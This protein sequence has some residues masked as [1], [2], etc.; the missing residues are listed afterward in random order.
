MN[1]H[2]PP[3]AALRWF[4]I[5]AALVYLLGCSRGD[6][7]RAARIAA[8][9]DVSGLERA[10]AEK[11]VGYA[12]DPASLERDLRNF[13]AL[14]EAFR[15][16][17]TG[18]WG[19]E[20]AEEP[21]PKKYVKYTQNYLSRATVDFDAGTIKVET[22][23]EKKPEKSLHTA[24]V[25]TV[26]T[27]EDPRAVDLYSDKPV[28]L[29]E[30]PFLY[31]LVKDFDGKDIR[32]SWRA[33][34]FA[35]QLI[36]TNLK[37]RKIRAAGKEKTVRFVRFP[38]T[39]DRFH[40]RAKKYKP[41]VDQY[42]SRYGVSPNLIYAVIKTESDFN[43]FAVSPVPAFGLMQIVPGTAGADVYQFLHKKSGR[44]TRDAL[45]EPKVNILYGTTYLHML[46]TQYLAEIDNP[47]SREYCV[48][49]AYNAGAGNVLRTFDS[50]R[51][52]APSRI[53]ALPP[54][55]VYRTLQ[56]R[57]PSDEGRRYLV[58]VLEAKKD[59]VRF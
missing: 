55:E 15:R 16:L 25:T 2:S 3:S 19:E 56:A 36:Q 39:S 54:L 4:L 20:E 7:I 37:T 51:S 13:K 58:K 52:R 24:I 44:P 34:R 29:G 38:M 35:D 32:W 53:N 27:P 49:T 45:L 28:K 11:A 23:D 43:P 5:A 46:D 57:L 26:L 48:I 22:L 30:E 18:T 50:D 9:G 42:S 10:A 40:V 31:G 6:V 17:I 47:I 59:F 8:T 33:G 12:A 21:T 14:V 41:L 1:H